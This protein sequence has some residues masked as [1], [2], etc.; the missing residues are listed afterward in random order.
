M[1]TGKVIALL[2]LLSISGCVVHTGTPEVSLPIE[3]TIV[4]DSQF[5]D[6]EYSVRA[7]T[8]LKGDI[9]VPDGEGP[10]PAVLLIHGGSWAGGSRS[11]M[12]GIAKRLARRGFVAFNIS[13]SFAPENLY[14]A[15]LE[16]CQSALSWMRT[17]RAEYKIRANKI[18]VW[19]FSAG[20]HLAALLGTK[21]SNNIENNEF[22]G[23]QAVVA[24]SAPHNL[25]K[26][27]DSKAIIDLLGTTIEQD[28]DIFKEAS[29]LYQVGEKTPPMF[30]YHGSWDKIVDLSHSID[31]KQAL[32]RAGVA[33]EFYLVKGLGHIPLFILGWGV[34]AHARNFLATHLQ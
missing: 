3:S 27:P 17:H 20:G 12:S 32:D 23:V 14:P 13:Y 31:M 7:E 19:G 28:S 16:D 24:G 26:Y 22:Q 6:L 2:S 4:G 1:S 33:N 11:H 30:L 5:S 34:E 25:T 9:Y 15:Q 8:S 10:F 29:P 18:G 21:S